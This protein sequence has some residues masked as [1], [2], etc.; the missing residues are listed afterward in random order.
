MDW[1]RQY[2]ASLPLHIH[3]FGLYSGHHDASQVATTF[4]FAAYNWPAQNRGVY[5]PISIPWAYPV[6]RVFWANGSTITTSS[7][8]FAIYNVDGVRLMTTGVTAQSGA[9]LFQYVDVTDFILPAGVYYFFLSNNSATVTS[10]AFG[11]SEIKTQEGRVGGLL[12]QA[13]VEAAPTTA[14][15]EAWASTGLP[16]CGV[17]RTASGF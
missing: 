3:T 4:T 9:S 10:R 2:D 12:Q 6:A 17:T 7:M 13:S 5:I 14:T 1:P 8:C 15:F 11:N 16:L